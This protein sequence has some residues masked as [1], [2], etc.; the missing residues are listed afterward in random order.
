M[1]PRT[2]AMSRMG[3]MG[4]A[5]DENLRSDAGKAP[6]GDVNYRMADTPEMSCMACKHFIADSACD[7]VAGRIDPNGVSD[8]FEPGVPGPPSGAPPTTAGPVGP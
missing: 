1:D 4:V 2:T 7:V 3:A 6:M 5:P 8:L